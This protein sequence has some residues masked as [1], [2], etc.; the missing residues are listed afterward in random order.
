MQAYDVSKNVSIFDNAFEGSKTNQFYSL[1]ID[2]YDTGDI[3][4]IQWGLTKDWNNNH[5]STTLYLYYLFAWM[6]WWWN[7]IST[8]F[9]FWNNLQFCFIGRRSHCMIVKVEIEINDF[10][11]SS[12]NF[13][14]LQ[15]FLK[16]AC[17]IIIQV[18]FINVW[19]DE[20]V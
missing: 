10:I 15:Y 7:E 11:Q 9:I 1:T 12:I 4:S 20:G 13:H 5:T 16:H 2:I 17:A 18:V 3:I 6:I 14:F 19:F 8:H